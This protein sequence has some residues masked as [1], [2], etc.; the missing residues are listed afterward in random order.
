MAIHNVTV[1]LGGSR[2]IEIE[3]GKM[4]L[5]AS[6]S[7]T[8]RMGDTIVMVAACSAD[9]RPGLDFFPLQVDYREKFSAAGRMPGG[10]FKREGRPSEKE[11]LTARMT[12][13]PLRPLF[14][15]GF[16]DDVQIQALLLSADLENDP[17]VLSILGASVALAISDI[18]FGGPI[19]ALRVGR[20]DGEFIANPT[21]EQMEV[22]E[23]DLV[24]AG[25]ED[26][27]IMIEGGGNEISE[28]VLRDALSFANDI[29]KKQIAAQLELVAACG[30]AKYTPS[31]KSIPEDISAAVKQAAQ[32]RLDNITELG[33]RE[34]RQVALDAVLA[35]IVE[36]IGESLVT[37][38]RDEDDVKGHMKAAFSNEF[39][40]RMRDTILED[41][42][43]MD[44]RD[45]KSLR[46][47]TS[48]VSVLPRVHGSAMFARG[49]TQ[50]LVIT[51]LG[52]SK[53][54]QGFDAISGG[55]NSKNFLLHYNF[56]NYSVGETGRIMGPGRREVGHGNLAERSV[57]KVIP[58]MEDFPYTIRCVS[59]VMGSNGSTSMASICGAVLSLMD[60]GVPIK[61]PVA[62]IS[63][64]LI[65]KG[66]DYVMI[67]DILGAEDHYGD[68]DFK[69]AG[70]REG[71]TGY[72]LD[73]KIAGI[74]IDMM[75]EAMLQI[76]TSRME[77]IDNMEA[78]IAAPR[79][80]LSEWAPQ[81]KSI[82][83]NPE[84]IGALIGPGGSMIKSITAET[85]VQ[86]DIQDDG[87][88]KIFSNNKANIEAALQLIGAV[89]AEAEVGKIYRAT[90]KSIKDFGCFCEILPGQEG[91]CHISEL[92]NYRVN[93]VSDVVS[94]GEK[95]T[96]KL[97]EIDDR[98]RLRLSRKAAMDEL[99]ES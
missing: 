45:E 8:I 71:I 52:S 4:A 86:I 53:D 79:E 3:T 51:T 96:V 18:P 78:C 2:S 33:S 66:D 62:G 47:I 95:I 76:K 80:E 70:T 82:T 67:T 64:G 1:D 23:I 32:G 68:M 81:I 89:V 87:T 42:K 7:V 30:K 88:V 9:P 61:A 84:K 40:E 19:G 27:T 5:L 94:E 43:R 83:I 20:V 36:Q 6:G 11:I 48:E 38:D 92:A 59:E 65:Q 50:A 17:D 15:E 16:Y 35:D 25:I 10:Y 63:C 85:E 29:V 14:P 60:A 28:E 75:Y 22:S 69:I 46:P 34:E 12:D 54:V 41:K 39:T 93:E 49:E 74:S 57:E 72:Q 37:E 56:P 44:G 97:L 98:G 26:K 13:R 77:I 21:H 24:Y 55:P 58:S 99:D 31:L 91:L 90:V 73:L